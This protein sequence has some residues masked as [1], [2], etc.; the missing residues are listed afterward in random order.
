MM[1]KVALNS[2]QPV[3]YME[4]IVLCSCVTRYL[5]VG[6]LINWAGVFCQKVKASLS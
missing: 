4:L 6:I 5:C 3:H 1:L 2:N